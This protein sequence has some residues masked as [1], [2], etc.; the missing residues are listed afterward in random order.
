M[1][2]QAESGVDLLEVVREHSG[3]GDLRADY[4]RPVDVGPDDLEDYIYLKALTTSV[5]SVSD[6]ISAPDG[7]FLFVKV[8]QKRQ[9]KSLDIARGDIRSKLIH[10]HRREVWNDYRDKMYS[11]YG[12]KFD[13]NVKLIVLGNYHERRGE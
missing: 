5:G 9:S 13:K 2:D 12:I 6:M 1:R 4:A 11:R 7:S 8:L 10:S 3:T